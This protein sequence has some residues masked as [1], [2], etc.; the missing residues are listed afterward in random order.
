VIKKF[1]TLIFNKFS[2]KG[3]IEETAI[4]GFFEKT[5]KKSGRRDL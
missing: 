1:L 3:R 5:V 4:C 2:R